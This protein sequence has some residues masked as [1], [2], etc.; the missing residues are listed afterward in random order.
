M[1]T[2][3]VSNS[4]NPY[5]ITKIFI[6]TAL[7][8]VGMGILLV[9]ALSNFHVYEET[10]SSQT[11]MALLMVFNEFLF[12]FIIGDQQH[13]LPKIHLNFLNKITLALNLQ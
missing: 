9:N 1:S 13:E 2:V 3:V 12:C 5:T 10:I 4:C 6:Y 8:L 11:V 7:V